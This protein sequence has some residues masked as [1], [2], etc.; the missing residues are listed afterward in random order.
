MIKASEV[1]LTAAE[2]S[3]RSC[4]SQANFYCYRQALIEA[5]VIKE[6]LLKIHHRGAPATTFVAGEAELPAKAETGSKE[7]DVLTD[8]QLEVLLCLSNGKTN[9]EAGQILGISELTVKNHVQTILLKLGTPT[10]AGAVGTA[11][12]TGLLLVPV[13]RNRNVGAA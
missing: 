5:G 9:S 13:K 7:G 1:P 3:T 10:R 11:F 8:R 2:I 4:T 12:R 6:S